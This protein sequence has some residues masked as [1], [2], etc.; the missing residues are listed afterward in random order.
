M[1]SMSVKQFGKN[2][3][4][5]LDPNCLQKLLADDTSMQRVNV[6]WKLNYLTLVVPKMEKVCSDKKPQIRLLGVQTK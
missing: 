2:D 4:P 1:R 3:S 5:D 6:F